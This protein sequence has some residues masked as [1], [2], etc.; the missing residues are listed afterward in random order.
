M[1]TDNVGEKCRAKNDHH[2][3]GHENYRRSIFNY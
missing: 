2:C 3:D 1:N